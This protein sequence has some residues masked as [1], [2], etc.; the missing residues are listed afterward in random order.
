MWL[1]TVLE[2]EFAAAMICLAA[3]YGRKYYMNWRPYIV[4]SFA[5]GSLV[6][7]LVYLITY[8]WTYN[9]SLVSV[10]PMPSQLSSLYLVS[11]YTIFVI[12][13]ALVVGI[14]VSIYSWKYLSKEDNAGPFFALLILLLTCVIGVVSAGDFLTL[15]LFWEGM[16]IS[17]YGLVAFYK[18]SSQISLEASLK[19]IFLAGAGSLLA[20]YGISLV[21][22]A[23]GSIALSSISALFTG[24]QTIGILA[25][26]MIILG[27]GVEAAIFPLYT[28]LPDVY[29]AAP[30]PVSAVISGI[31]TE[32]GIFVLLKVIQPLSTTSLTQ[33]VNTFLKASSYQEIPIMLTVLAALTM[34]AGN[35]GAY[36]QTNLKRILAFSSIAQMGY[37]LAALSTFSI[38]GIAAVVFMIWNHGITKSGFFL[39]SG[40]KGKKYEDSELD[41]LQG[42]GQKNKAVGI[43]YA[44][45]S[46]AMV[47]S[48]PFGMFWAE[49]FIVEALL[50]ASSES[51][52]ILGVIVVLN[53]FLSLAYYLKIINKVAF[54]PSPNQQ[55]NVQ[56]AEGVSLGLL[57]P[58]LCLIALSLFTGIFPYVLLNHLM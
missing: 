20:L 22:S 46:L 26:I 29:S 8:W 4:G 23:T 5:T 44:S 28:W 15:F 58:P 11:N 31:V 3:D 33:N 27:F 39:M 2:I 12:F 16:S 57:M 32:S 18:E 21:Y 55:Q 41:S 51:F 34:F 42:L 56:K 37:M 10:Q 1:I 49:L 35:L 30:I 24:S 14:A 47:G 45:S 13:T 54:N 53:I 19:Y 9:G 38:L 6:V 43:M 7:S 50:A 36:V 17:A 48:P 25:L 40:L 52:L